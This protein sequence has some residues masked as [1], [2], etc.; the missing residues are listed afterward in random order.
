[1]KIFTKI[2]A[3]LLLIVAVVSVSCR[4]SNNSKYFYDAKKDTSAPI[5]NISV[6]IK[7]DT[8]NYGDDIHIVGT[9]TDL[10][11]A[12]FGGKLSTL[13]IKIDELHNWDSTFVGVM[14]QKNPAVDAKEGYPF[15]EKMLIFSGA[16]PTFCRLEV[17]AADYS[18]KTTR[19]TVYF[20]IQ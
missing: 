20:H 15:N 8:Y 19:D 2:L 10:Q 3:V 4:R 18:G 6:P 17:A 1:M 9:V 13:S 14:L 7:N 5:I 12:G 16:N 11:T